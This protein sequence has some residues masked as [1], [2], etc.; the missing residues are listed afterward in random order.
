MGLPLR[1][2]VNQKHG[3]PLANSVRLPDLI[4]LRT[5]NTFYPQNYIWWQ[6][7]DLTEQLL[8]TDR[9]RMG[10]LTSHHS[11]YAPLDMSKLL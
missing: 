5:L 6:K 3:S 11:A 10:S 7:E 4:L 2:S 9:R 8:T 1:I